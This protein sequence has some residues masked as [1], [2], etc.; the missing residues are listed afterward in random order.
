MQWNLSYSGSLVP[1]KLKVL[2]FTYHII[3]YIMT[4]LTTFY[5]QL[6]GSHTI[7]MAKNY[8]YS[9]KYDKPIYRCVNIIVVTERGCI[10]NTYTTTRDEP[11][12]LE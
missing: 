1:C 11:I 2:W 8:S 9:Y 4:N 7:C 12:M 6:H 3:S 5:N 10:A